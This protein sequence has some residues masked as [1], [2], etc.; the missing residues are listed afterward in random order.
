MAHV[1]LTPVGLGIRHIP[2]DF[3]QNFKIQDLFYLNVKMFL[4]ELF[5]RPS[6]I[7][8][9]ATYL[10]DSCDGVV[11]YPTDLKVLNI[12]ETCHI[13]SYVTEVSTLPAVQLL[14]RLPDVL[15]MTFLAGDTVDDITAL[16][17]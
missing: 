3:F 4:I 8:I 16:A 2:S 1:A 11:L 7:H 12:W 9:V 14:L 5:P 6:C 17:R 10:L 15:V 13:K